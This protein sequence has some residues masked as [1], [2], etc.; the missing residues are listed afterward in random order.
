MMPRTSIDAS[1]DTCLLGYS[2]LHCHCPKE[3]TA[4]CQCDRPDKPTLELCSRSTTDS[5][6][7]IHIY[8]RGSAQISTAKMGKDFLS[9]ACVCGG[10]TAGG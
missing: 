6:L 1:L 2:S 9:F 8:A 4:K 7:P 3:C 10:L 5:A